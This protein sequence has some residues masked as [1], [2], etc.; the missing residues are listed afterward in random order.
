MFFNTP[1]AISEIQSM[2]YISNLLGKPPFARISTIHSAKGRRELGSPTESYGK[3][4]I[5]SKHRTSK[6]VLPFQHHN[7]SEKT[8][9]KK[10]LI[11]HKKGLTLDTNENTIEKGILESLGTRPSTR[12]FTSAQSM[13]NMNH[14]IRSKYGTQSQ[15]R[16]TLSNA[17]AM[18]TKSFIKGSRVSTASEMNRRTLMCTAEDQ[19]SKDFTDDFIQEKYHNLRFVQ[20]SPKEFMKLLKLTNWDATLIPNDS[21]RIIVEAIMRDYFLNLIPENSDYLICKNSQSH[22]YSVLFTGKLVPVCKACTSLAYFEVSRDLGFQVTCT[23]QYCPVK[24]LYRNGLSDYTIDC[25]WPANPRGDVEPSLQIKT[26]IR[27]P[28]ISKLVI[29]GK[30]KLSNLSRVISDK[31]LMKAS[32]I[33][34]RPN[35]TANI[36][37][38]SS[39]APKFTR[40]VIKSALEEHSSPQNLPDMQRPNTT[41]GLVKPLNKVGNRPGT[42]GS[43]DPREFKGLPILQELEERKLFTREKIERKMKEEVILETA[44]DE[45]PA[46]STQKRQGNNEILVVPDLGVSPEEQVSEVVKEDHEIIKTESYRPLKDKQYFFDG[47]D[48]ERMDTSMDDLHDMMSLITNN[49]VK[50]TSP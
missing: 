24:I 38:S 9:P 40:V 10:R 15:Q 8:L 20:T 11:P 3:L 41:Q 22:I 42:S 46:I 36:M 43:V 48:R 25:L 44:G 39:T 33:N 4:Y 49:G 26:G 47:Q 34:V 2:N 12:P 28:H 32:E 29:S 1:N 35:T 23:S 30:Y 19:D 50:S 5:G 37:R 16:L 18:T 6:P 7:Q 13:R 17:F 21:R 45:D 14:S 31:S 27:T